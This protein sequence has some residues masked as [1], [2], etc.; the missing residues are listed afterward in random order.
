M[1]PAIFKVASE[2]NKIMGKFYGK[3]VLVQNKV[4]KDVYFLLEL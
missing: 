3:A 2:R 1:S 4:T